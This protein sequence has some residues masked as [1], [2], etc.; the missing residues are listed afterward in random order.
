[1]NNMSSNSI[2][3]PSIEQEYPL[4]DRAID[5]YRQNGH[6]L[7]RSVTSE[8]IIRAYRPH[9]DV[10]VQREWSERPERWTGAY[11]NAFIH[12]MNV[13]QKNEAMRKFVF[14]ARFAEIAA[15]LMG[16]SGIRLYYDT[17]LYKTPD[18]DHTPTHVDPFVVDASKVITMWMPF[19]PITE[20][21]GSLQFIS[22][23]HD[24]G[25]ETIPPL[26]IICNAVRKGLH[27]VSYGTMNLGDATFHAG[28]M[29]HG[30]PKNKDSIIRKV[31]AIT[32]FADGEKLISPGGER[33]RMRHAEE[34]FHGLH[35]GDK[36]DSLMTP[37]LY[38]K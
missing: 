3:L 28:Y 22:G 37:V 15:K 23:S 38:R 34:L 30:A 26:Q 12:V 24:L 8:E 17:A 7:L 11:A 21:M 5:G 9:L 35:T 2:M 16:V 27:L 10:T 29:A 20:N 14:A 36:A 6:I 33:I 25:G 19:V 1:M 18:G 13:W 32:Y 4:S 31:L